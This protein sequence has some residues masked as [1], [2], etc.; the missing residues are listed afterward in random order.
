MSTVA[1][2]TG[3]AAAATASTGLLGLVAHCAADQETLTEDS[4]F[5]DVEGYATSKSCSRDESEASSS[6]EDE[7]SG[8]FFMLLAG[9]LTV[10]SGLGYS[11]G[12]ALKTIGK[13]VAFYVGVT[14]VGIQVLAYNE[15]VKTDWGK[16]FRIIEASLDANND[17]KFDLR[18]AKIWWNRLMSMMTFGVPGS[19]SFL[20]GFYL[21]LRA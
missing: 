7:A 5:D 14:F 18:D 20:C 4:E 2:A 11:A 6:D 9:Q 3:V 16:A 8:P 21:G 19:G 12:Y 15:I 17:G 13:K 10:G 1:K